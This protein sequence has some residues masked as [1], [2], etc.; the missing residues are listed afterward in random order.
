MVK[1]LD[2]TGEI[3]GNAYLLTST[4]VLAPTDM[5]SSQHDLLSKYQKVLTYDATNHMFVENLTDPH[6]GFFIVP[7]LKICIF[8]LKTV[9][10]GYTLQRMGDL[11]NQKEIESLRIFCCSRKTPYPHVEPLVCKI[12]KTDDKFVTYEL[13]HTHVESGAMLFSGDRFVGWHVDDGENIKSYGI[14]AKAFIDW[15]IGIINTGQPG[16]EV[17]REAILQRF[18]TPVESILS[19]PSPYQ[20]SPSVQDLPSPFPSPIKMVGIT[21]E[22]CLKDYTN[23]AIRF[24]SKTQIVTVLDTDTQDTTSFRCD[25]SIN[26]GCCLIGTSHGVLITGSSAQE[27]NGAWMFT[28]ENLY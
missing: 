23:C 10:K 19:S 18:Q 8:A 3:I 26:D 1:L 7:E 20:S 25:A 4:H 11:V 5:I 17:L 12:T 24:S 27:N 22:A 15:A 6:G 14:L 28:G 13:N 9:A 2:S 16:H 21:L